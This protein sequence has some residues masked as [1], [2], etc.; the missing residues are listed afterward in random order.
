M[1]IRNRRNTGVVALT[2]IFSV[3]AYGQE[4]SIGAIVTKKAGL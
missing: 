3:L 2:L 4:E 1:N